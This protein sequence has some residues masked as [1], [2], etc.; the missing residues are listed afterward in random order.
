MKSRIFV[1]VI[2]DEKVSH[3]WVE[4]RLLR[5]LKDAMQMS[6]YCCCCVPARPK[7][8]STTLFNNFRNPSSL[9][10]LLLSASSTSFSSS[11]SPVAPPSSSSPLDTRDFDLKFLSHSSTIF[12][13]DVTFF[14][15]AFNDATDEKSC[16]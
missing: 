7:Y 5:M 10:G 9:Y 15:S 3:H 12:K 4:S 2:S 11:W 6:P 1:F 14:L 13:T 8:R 16:L